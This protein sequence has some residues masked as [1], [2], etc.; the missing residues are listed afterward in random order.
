MKTQIL[1][2]MALFILIVTGLLAGNF[3]PGLAQQAVGDIVSFSQ[4]SQKE[5]VLQGPLDIQSF[6]F[7]LPADWE[8]IDGSQLHVNYNAFFNDTAA[9]AANPNGI[10]VAGYIQ[11]TLNDVPVGTIVLDNRGENSIDLPIPNIAWA[12]SDPKKTTRSLQFYLKTAEECHPTSG[13][14][15]NPQ[16]GLSVIVR[17]SSYFLLPHR[18]A[19]IV[20]DLRRLPYPIYQDSFLPDA[21]VLV[22]PDNPTEAELQAVLTTSAVFGRMTGNLLTLKTVAVSRLDSASLTDS[23]LIFVGK[24]SSFPQLSQATWPAPING[25][26][27]SNPQLGAEDGILQVAVSP[28]NPA[29]IW[30]LVSGQSDAGIVKAAQALGSG[31]IRADQ[32]PNL[33][34]VS[35][36]QS[37]PVTSLGLTDHTFADLGYSTETRWGPGIRFIAYR[38]QIPPGQVV[39]QDAYVD[40]VFSHSSMFDF[41]QA[42]LSISLNS[43]YI[44]SFRFSER[45]AQVSNWRL[46]LPSASFQPGVN[47]LLIE[48]NLEPVTH[49][50][51]NQELWFTTRPESVLHTPT[52]AAPDEV[53][54]SNLKDYPAPFA[55]TLDKIA[56]ILAPNDPDSW[57]VASKL[58][59]DLGARTGGTL[60]DPVVSFADKVPDA[61]KK[62]RDLLL[63]GRPSAMPVMQELASA[64]PAPFDAGSD[65]AK[66]P[67]GA[68]TFKVSPNTPVGYL[69]IFPAPW[70]P[71]HSVMTISA[72]GP[73]GLTW[74]ADALITSDQRSQLTGNLAVLYNNQIIA[75][76]VSGAVAIATPVASSTQAVQSQ[77]GQPA[78]LN[79]FVISGIAVAVLIALGLLVWRIG[80]RRNER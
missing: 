58:A 79:M 39:T 28:L 2:R 78:G 62:D 63:I 57:S 69:Q 36:T 44:G 27:F 53:A 75:T 9:S 66:E 4:L 61:V 25:D 31:E 54:S 16:T 51:P 65:I 15:T 32:Q 1:V 14:V 13:Y 37:L 33:S 48:A 59:F 46:N 52:Q 40:L 74:G 68:F 50:I 77:P 72:N 73:D 29:R 64:M 49:C 26:G 56:F 34:I 35:A 60:I 11:V 5:I 42:G 67:P 43:D 17:S 71:K 22:M 55:P 76:Q 38:F 19:P 30:L 7:N 45:T 6:A 21:A 24:P 12:T 80:A 20:T 18:Q 41:Q 10:T 47:L 23:H 70:N 3:Q 8:I